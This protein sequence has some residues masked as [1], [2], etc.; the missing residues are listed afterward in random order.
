MPKNFLCYKCTF[1]N[2]LVLTGDSLYTLP[3]VSL[4]L[5]SLNPEQRDAATTIHGPLL[6]LAGAGTGKTRVITYRMVHLLTQGI[7]PE[8]ILAVTFTNKAAR[9]M[10]ERFVQLVKTVPHLDAQAVAKKSVIGTFHSFCMRVLRQKIEVLGY[11]G[12]FS[13][14]DES[15]QTGL[16][17]KIITRVG[18]KTEKLDNRLAASLIS[19]SKNRNTPIQ[20]ITRDDMVWEVCRQYQETLKLQN[21][22]DF[23]DLLTLTVRL[24]RDHSKVREELRNMHRYFLIDEYQ[25]TNGLQFE[26]VRQLASDKHDV[27]AVGDDDQSIYSWRGAE[28]GN[29]LNFEHHFP[30]AKI[31]KLEQNYRSTPTILGVANRVILNNARRRPKK[32]WAKGREGEKVRLITAQSDTEEAEWVVADI[33]S[34]CRSEGRTWEEVV[35]LYRMNAQSRA[36]EQ[37]L[38]RFRIPYRM[39]GGLSFYER[40][41]VKDVLSY[42]QV[43]LNPDD[44]VSLLRIINTPPRGI[45]ETTIEML[46]ENSRKKKIPIWREILHCVEIKEKLADKLAPFV[47]LIQSYKHRLEHEPRRSE[48]LKELL[49]M[50]G[51]FKDLERSCKEPQE[52]INRGENVRELITSLEEFEK[53]GRGGLR[54]FIDVMVLERERDDEKELSDA[55]VTLM[56]L[57]SAKGLEFPHVYLIGME[58]GT[59]PHERSKVEG[60]VDEERRLLYVGITRAREKLSISYCLTRRKYGQDMLC[61]PSSFLKELPEESLVRQAAS[62]CRKP[63]ATGAAATQLAALKARLG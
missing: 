10:K 50:I 40:R 41:E 5:D 27:C 60:N 14:F 32:L 3:P 6:V 59:L 12:N 48:A 11:N 13:I 19:L 9:E 52:Y 1:L 39:I 42:L 46:L 18:G 61:S 16:L 63:A 8:H 28:S 22:V 62:E 47:Q 45:G 25:D 33:A 26:I 20:N 29:I 7:L 55:G 43:V 44:D 53:R 54:E 51:F 2:W 58:E 36:I 4:D 31:V 57:H 56:T 34:L 30:G 21:A 37:E 38:R 23:D 35:V 49:D 24:L 15:D 17:K